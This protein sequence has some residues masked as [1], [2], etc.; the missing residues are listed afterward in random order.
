MLVMPKKL[1][2][3]F[4]VMNHNDLEHWKK[5]LVTVPQAIAQEDQNVC[6]YEAQL[7][8]LNNELNTLHAEHLAPIEKQIN[9]LEAQIKI[10]TLPEKIASLRSIASLLQ[11][12][13]EIER[14][15]LSEVKHT[16]ANYDT[17]ITQLQARIKI[18]ELD[19]QIKSLE[20]D[21]CRK[22]LELCKLKHELAKKRD[23]FLL[24]RNCIN[25]NRH[26]T[27]TN[28]F[29][30]A[31]SNFTSSGQQQGQ[32]F[33]S[34]KQQEGQGFTSSKQQEGLGF[35]SSRQSVDDYDTRKPNLALE[36]NPYRVKEDQLNDCIQELTVAINRKQLEISK[37]NSEILE[38]QST[39][40]CYGQ[41][42]ARLAQIESIT[43]LRLEELNQISA[44]ALQ[45]REEDKLTLAL[46]KLSSSYDETN[47]QINQLNV[48]LEG[49]FSRRKKF[50]DNT[51]VN[52]L[53][54]FDN[55][56][57]TDLNNQLREQ[58][59]E[60]APFLENKKQLNVQIN[61]MDSLITS[62]KQTI[63]KL[64][65][66]LHNLNNDHFK[67]TLSI[68]PEELITKM[69]LLTY[70]TL[71]L[72]EKQHPAKQSDQVRLSLAEIMDKLNYFQNAPTD[73]ALYNEYVFNVYPTQLKYYQ[74][75]GLLW[76]ELDKLKE[77]D[78]YHLAE[79]IL[80]IL[81]SNPIES[82]FAI[83][84]YDKLCSQ[85]RNI[86]QP[87]DM[88]KLCRS[89]QCAH[90]EARKN[91]LKLITDLKSDAQKERRQV[92]QTGTDVLDS[93]VGK[94]D[95]Q[96]QVGALKYHTN[97]LQTAEQRI[98]KSN[99]EEIKKTLH[100][101]IEANDDDASMYKKVVGALS[102]GFGLFAKKESKTAM[103]NFEKAVNNV[104]SFPLGFRMLSQEASNA[105]SAKPDAPKCLFFPPKPS[106]PPLDVPA[107]TQNQSLYP[108]LRDFKFN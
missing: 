27:R 67:K 50:F 8:T 58:R 16:I 57:L 94:K 102:T 83:A 88:T 7:A 51:R 75:C 60:L 29:G 80:S 87:I 92:Y 99:D 46:A 17:I 97:F 78:D 13:I 70:Q 25:M 36:V 40:R 52:G 22:D 90:D 43:Q 41:N 86:L 4:T 49:C 66:Q 79:A 42:E 34:S 105:E 95:K 1:D 74:L 31:H 76:T 85:Q 54:V 44:K 23:E 18:K 91:F 14:K 26:D 73:Q 59:V 71:Q 98:R 82:A 104:K 19:A 101:L 38:K 65:A 103:L 5:L 63:A 6:D 24:L 30:Q 20:S 21:K 64:Q 32:G 48:V 9:D 37:F 93:F 3:N 106:A 84:E 12:E 2:K 56:D 39:L 69:I 72:F 96:Q 108:D 45:T 89:E 11:V 81:K 28:H 47:S 55:K 68:Q 10:L 15:R 35:T 100:E 53:S 62:S 61:K 33:T 107:T 77:D